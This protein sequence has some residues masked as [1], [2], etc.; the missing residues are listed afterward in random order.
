MS[1]LDAYD[2]IPS[3]RAKQDE[4]KRIQTDPEYARRVLAKE[5][6]SRHAAEAQIWEGLPS[7]CNREDMQEENTRFPNRS[8]AFYTN[9][10]TGKG[11]QRN[12]IT[13]EWNAIAGNGQVPKSIEAL[14]ADARSRRMDNY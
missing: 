1:F 14:M 9:A 13:G 2:D 3:L 5:E 12:R 11:Y 8:Y 10:A 4:K 7:D 6:A